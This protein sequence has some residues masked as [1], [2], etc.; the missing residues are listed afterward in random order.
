MS[1]T[2]SYN[3]K[4]KMPQGNINRDYVK[5]DDSGYYAP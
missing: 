2:E 4:G 3:T 1:N 5:N